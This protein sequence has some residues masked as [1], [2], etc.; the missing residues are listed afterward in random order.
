MRPYHSQTPTLAQQA[1][2]LRAAQPGSTVRFDRR[3]SR[4]VWDGRLSPTATSDRYHTRIVCSRQQPQPR[5]FIVSPALIERDGEA[6]PHRYDDT[7]LCLWQPAYH[8]WQPAYWI[9]D[10]VI[11]W[12]ALWLFFY[13]LWHACGE[14][15]GGGEHP[16]DEHRSDVNESNA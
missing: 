8:E 3:G 6:I 4:M 14:W 1:F 5:V 2:R 12:T 10:T 16:G 13:E 15:L 7:S 11:G 9:A